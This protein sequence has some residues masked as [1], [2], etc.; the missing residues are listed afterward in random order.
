[1][2]PTNIDLLDPNKVPWSIM[3]PVMSADITEGTTNNLHPEGLYSV[4]IFGRVGTKERDSTLS[5]I[6]VKLP[7][8]NPTYLEALCQ[9][10]SLYGGIIRGTEYAVFDEVTKDF[11]KS[12][13][14]EG[15]TGFS[16]FIKHFKQL[17]PVLNKSNK[18]KQKI[19]LF[20]RYMDKSLSDKVLVIPAGLRDVQFS[21][22]GTNGGIRET[23]INE[24]YR[25]L[26]FRSR[27]VVKS[28]DD[29]N[30]IY[31][32][33]RWSIQNSFKDID[34]YIFSMLEGKGG[35]LRKKMATRGTVGGTRNII[36]ARKVSRAH[37]DYDDGVNPN[38]TDQGMYQCLLAFQY[39]CKHALLNGWLSKVF[40][41][42][43]ETAKLVNPKTFEYEYVDVSNDIVDKW[44]SSDGLT[45]L[46]NGF[47]D[48]TLRNKPIKINGHYLGLVYDDGTFVK[49]VGSV[50]ELPE[51]KDKKHLTPLTYM[52]LF[53]LE[54]FEAISKKMV[55][56]TRFPIT[57]IGSIY[58]SYVNLKTTTVSGVR[59]TLDDYWEPSVQ[60]R[61]FPS[62]DKNVKYFDAMSVDPSKEELLG[63]D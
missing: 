48:T 47:K 58:P 18:R 46:I 50:D 4:E 34:D 37:A 13:V 49:I 3:K 59:T 14:L 32:N 52:E 36:T 45:K 7:I 12:N 22:M 21:P 60:C 31:D 2:K 17:E 16:F 53:Y 30:P 8:F 63:S 51:G 11:I 23:E 25:K 57:G 19:T 38:S 6:D 29:N 24:L 26:L 28:K 61:A 55:Q 15:Q 33:V 43:S 62:K 5:Y 40:T 42:G 41:V 9:L 1:M 54:T 56:L 10:K 27:S 20:K 44:M 39:I 35:V